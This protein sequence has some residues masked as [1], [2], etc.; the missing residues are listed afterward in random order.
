[1]AARST[2]FK[3][4]LF[5]TIGIFLAAGLIVWLGASTYFRQAK[6][7]VTY[8]NESVQGLSVDSLVK[9]RGVT[10]GRVQSIGVAPDYKLIEVVMQINFQGDLAHEVAAQLKTVGITGLVFI[11]L[12]RIKDG[13]TADSPQITFPSE[14]PIIPSRP[15]EITHIMS[16]VNEVA[17]RLRK[18]DFAGIAADFRTALAGV[19]RFFD[20]KRMNAAMDNLAAAAAGLHK[21]TDHVAKFLASGEAQGAVK[22][23]K[24]AIVEAKQ[25]LVVLRRQLAQLKLGQITADTEG[26]IKGV[27]S[28]SQAVVDN[29]AATAEILRRAA[30]TMERLVQRLEA[31]PSQI[32]FSRPPAARGR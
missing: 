29:L 24:A 10:I 17:N 8:F 18:V 9:Y 28:K 5:V 22:E 13:D 6:R 3:V 2:K 25:T 14:Y 4:G 31:N 11:G 19:N 7:Y 12:D 27:R 1:M 20:G 15:S 23:A 26:L 21:V 30:E 16:V 32:L